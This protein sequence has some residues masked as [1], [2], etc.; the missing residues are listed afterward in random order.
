MDEAALDDA[1]ADSEPAAAPP[2]QGELKDA[3]KGM[4]GSALAVHGR[5]LDV[6]GAMSYSLP[7][8]VA[9]SFVIAV[10]ANALCFVWVD[11]AVSSMQVKHPS[12]KSDGP[13]IFV[14]DICT[15]PTCEFSPGT[16]ST[17]CQ[18]VQGASLA[19]QAPAMGQA[20][21]F[22]A[23]ELVTNSSSYS[24]MSAGLTLPRQLSGAAASL[25]AIQEALLQQPAARSGDV[26]SIMYGEGCM[27]SNAS[28]CPTAA[29]KWYPLTDNGLDSLLSAFC[30]SAQQLSRSDAQALLQPSFLFVWG[31]ADTFL[32]PALGT[33][34]KLFV[35][36]TFV[37]LDAGKVLLISVLVRHLSALPSP[38]ML[39]T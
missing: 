1:A 25:Q 20:V 16:V 22:W 38:Y 34:I 14:P 30:F 35:K 33:S 8:A 19:V 32:T 28:A 9:V 36:Q 5:K 27:A 11:Q 17:R 39:D 3:A 29:D 18:P 12:P 26:Q 24:Q 23:Q 2:L 7:G 21:V 4:P 37:S 31:I 13:L 15:R 10:T 6:R